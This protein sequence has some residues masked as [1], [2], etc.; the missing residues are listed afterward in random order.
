MDEVG[1]SP[2]QTL[3]ILPNFSLQK[4]SIPDG[5][6]STPLNPKGGAV[7]ASPGADTRV[8]VN[9]F[10]RKSV[11]PCP[12]GAFTFLGTSTRATAMLSPEARVEAAPSSRDSGVGDEIEAL[13][14]VVSRATTMPSP[15]AR[16]EAAPS[17]R[18][19]GVGGEIEALSGVVARL[20]DAVQSV[21]AAVQSL[22]L[23]LGSTI[24]G[25][26][27]RMTEQDANIQHLFVLAHRHERIQEQPG[28]RTAATRE[29]P[30]IGLLPPYSQLRR[31]QVLTS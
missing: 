23:E 28:V 27:D 5:S 21:D 2:P 31:I 22:A 13:S 30:V 19:S 26:K 20:S 10:Q 14:G 3:K 18:D 12:T 9:K 16:V 8:D 17:S 1:C 6:G 29:A 4:G 25:L 24:E 15:E 11:S 7:H